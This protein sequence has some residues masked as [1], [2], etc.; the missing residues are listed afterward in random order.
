MQGLHDPGGGERTLEV[1]GEAGGLQ[2]G[3]DSSQLRCA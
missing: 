1:E 3:L 2:V